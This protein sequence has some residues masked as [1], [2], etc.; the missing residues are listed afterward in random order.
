MKNAVLVTLGVLLCGCSTAPR[1]VI[2]FDSIDKEVTAI[3]SPTGQRLNGPDDELTLR[4]RYVNV[5]GT[6]VEINRFVLQVSSWVLEVV[7]EDG[8]PLP[9]IPLTY[10]SDEELARYGKV[11]RPGATYSVVYR[12]VLH[13]YMCKMPPGRYTVR[14]RGI[15]TNPVDVELMTGRE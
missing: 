3:L 15:P 10:H 4:C 11:L 2:R 6:D 9:T 8:K 14:V 12:D 5:S 7:G 1:A 13:A